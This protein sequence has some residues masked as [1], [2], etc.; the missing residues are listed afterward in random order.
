M[1]IRVKENVRFSLDDLKSYKNNNFRLFLYT[2]TGSGEMRLT[3]TLFNNSYLP[4]KR[5]SS[6]Y[7]RED[8]DIEDRW[9]TSTNL[10]PDLGP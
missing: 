5:C 8:P 6:A 4:Y 3:V 10:Y 1:D 9:I 2:Q 7:V